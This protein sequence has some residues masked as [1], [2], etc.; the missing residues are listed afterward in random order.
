MPGVGGFRKCDLASCGLW[1]NATGQIAAGGCGSWVC[2]CLKRIFGRTPYPHWLH[3]NVHKCRLG[4]TL[5][6]SCCIAADI[7]LPGRPCSRSME[8]S[9]RDCNK[10]SKRNKKGFWI[11]PVVAALPA[12]AAPGSKKCVICLTTQPPRA[13]YCRTV[14]KGNE[15]G[16]QQLAVTSDL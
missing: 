5:V 8:S 9:T 12:A 16:D 10:N 6:F 1:P 13:H 7:W 2:C 4:S 14:T 11:H 3:V 15:D